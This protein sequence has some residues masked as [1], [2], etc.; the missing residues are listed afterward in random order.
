MKNE[1]LCVLVLKHGEQVNVVL[2]LFSELQNRLLSS[3]VTIREDARH[4]INQTLREL[5]LPS[6][7]GV[8]HIITLYDIHDQELIRDTEFVINGESI[9]TL[10]DVLNN[11]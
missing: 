8:S 3:Y 5:E 1:D 7:V 11:I 6:I 4:E 10:F 2:K 9:F